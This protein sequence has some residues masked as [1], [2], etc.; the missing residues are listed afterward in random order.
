[1]KENKSGFPALEILLTLGAGALILAVANGDKLPTDFLP[2]PMHLGKTY[3]EI[4]KPTTRRVVSEKLNDLPIALE[5][6]SFGDI[7]L[8]RPPFSETLKMHHIIP[9]QK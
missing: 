5:Y 3:G 7:N 4:H 8:D 9:G 1:M 6:V 2:E